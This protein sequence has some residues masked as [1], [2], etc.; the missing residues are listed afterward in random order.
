MQEQKLTGSI[1]FAFS[2]IDESGSA[3]GSP[4]GM[5]D[6]DCGLTDPSLI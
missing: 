3:A 6:L 5:Y 2:N 1:G 4:P